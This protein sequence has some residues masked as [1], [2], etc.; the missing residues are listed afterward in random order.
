MAT[1]FVRHLVEDYESWREV[2][3]DF[4]ATRQEAGVT[5]EA[6]YRSADEPN[7]ITLVLDFAELETARSFPENEKLQAAFEKAGSIGPPTIWFATKD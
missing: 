4:F 6:V 5:T 7:E 2:F 1:M 3:D